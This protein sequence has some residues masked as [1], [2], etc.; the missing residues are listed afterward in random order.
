MPG[1]RAART[2]DETGVAPAPA[3]AQRWAAVGAGAVSASALAGAVGLATGTD[4]YL[5]HL[6]ERLP[7]HSPVLGAAALTAVVGVPYGLLAWDTWTGR[8][9]AASIAVAAG[10]LLVAWIGVEA[11]VL[12]ETSVLD[13]LYAGI[14]L[15][16]LV[17]G[18]RHRPRRVTD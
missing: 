16:T 3:A 18:R 10:S 4:P 5:A 13:P 9:R 2:A 6:T 17:L 12:R 15:A 1:S 8:R 11:A 14:G 7:L